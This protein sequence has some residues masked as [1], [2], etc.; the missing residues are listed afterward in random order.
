[1]T[2]RWSKRTVAVTESSSPGLSYNN[3]RGFDDDDIASYCNIETVAPLQSEIQQS[4]YW[5]CCSCGDGPQ[6]TVYNSACPNCAH[7]QCSACAT[8]T[9]D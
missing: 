4:L 3:M 5:Y 1:M 6:S 7:S 9:M 8:T 2:Y